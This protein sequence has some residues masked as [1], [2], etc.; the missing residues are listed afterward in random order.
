LTKHVGDGHFLAEHDR[1]CV[2]VGEGRCR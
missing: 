2:H 1:L